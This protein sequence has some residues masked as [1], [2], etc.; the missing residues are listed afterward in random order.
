MPS[1][2]LGT[3]SRVDKRVNEERT[4]RRTLIS[5]LDLMGRASGCGNL[6]P[7]P[8]GTGNTCTVAS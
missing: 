4:G 2:F 5:C 1:Q 8:Y 7:F 3:A 6:V